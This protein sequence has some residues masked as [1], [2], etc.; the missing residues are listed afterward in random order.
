[1]WEDKIQ[2]TKFGIDLKLIFERMKT[3]PSSFLFTYFD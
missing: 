3:L 1:M 2:L